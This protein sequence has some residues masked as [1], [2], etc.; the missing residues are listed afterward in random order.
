MRF[1]KA[2]ILSEIRDYNNRLILREYRIIPLELGI[3]K[4]RQNYLKYL[5]WANSENISRLKASMNLFI[6]AT[7]HQPKEFYKLFEEIMFR[8]SRTEKKI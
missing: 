7:F 3:R 4:F 1:I 6:D 8:Y 5:I 2:S